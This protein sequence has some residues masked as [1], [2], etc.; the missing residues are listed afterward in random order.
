MCHRDPQALANAREDLA[1]VEQDVVFEADPYEA[2]EGA[3]AIAM[4]TEWKLYNDL[5]YERIFAS[6]T[7]PAFLFD[8]RNIVD[9]ERLFE[10]G[11]NVCSIGKPELKH[12]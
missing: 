11:F 5:D 3:H 10:I 7:K 12:R 2:A 4:L 1:D 6:M 9:R 8:G